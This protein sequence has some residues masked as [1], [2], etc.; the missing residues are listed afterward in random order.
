MEYWKEEIWIKSQRGD[1]QPRALSIL[2]SVCWAQV[3]L[4]VD[5]GRQT[6]VSLG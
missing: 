5:E 4:W 3:V 2:T 1:P 6:A